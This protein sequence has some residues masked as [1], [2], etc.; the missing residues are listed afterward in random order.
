ML[1]E[2]GDVD[3]G[4]LQSTE[5]LYH[6]TRMQET[7]SGLGIRCYRWGVYAILALH[8]LSIVFHPP[9]PVSQLPNF[10]APDWALQPPCHGNHPQMLHRLACVNSISLQTPA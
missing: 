5:Y 3:M 10:R 9:S 7:L 6:R 1:G 8:A 4:E 2:M